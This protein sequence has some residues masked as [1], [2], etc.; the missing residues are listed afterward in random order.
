MSV[1]LVVP[2][3]RA[4]FAET[5]A[6]TV[7]SAPRRPAK[8]GARILLAG[9]DEAQ[10]LM[11]RGTLEADGYEVLPR[12][13]GRATVL[14]L[15]SEPFDL[16]LV[17]APIVDGSAAALLRWTRARRASAHMTCMV[18]VAPG[19][20]RLVAAL[21]DAG[22]DVVLTRRMQLGLLS[23]QVGAA[24]ARRPHAIAS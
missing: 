19:D 17:N 22:A 20:A 23:R 3:A 11:I 12:T 5:D 9:G 6:G 24:L 10:S 15:V 8:G 1:D 7:D 21:Y 13:T 4:P 2:R 14:A 16:L 18:M